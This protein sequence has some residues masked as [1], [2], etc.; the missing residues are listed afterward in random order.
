VG[1]EL[2]EHTGDL[3]VKI[4]SADL[5]G[6]FRE[7]AMALFDV[8]SDPDRIKV[9]EKR[10]IVVEGMNNEEL[11]VSWLNELLY[12]HE[13]ERLLFRD[14]EVIELG[15]GKLKGTAAGETFREDVHLIKTTL[16][17]VTYHQLEVKKENG[18]WSARIIFDV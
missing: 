7:A 18:G 1:Y 9:R 15:E 11:L 8:I 6:L 2:I 12:L 14:F 4:R 16:K 10:E 13:V 3:G 17:A 5:K